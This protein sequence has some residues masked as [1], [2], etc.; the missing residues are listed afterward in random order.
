MFSDCASSHPVGGT[1][2]QDTEGVQ[3]AADGSQRPHPNPLQSQVACR[4]SG[5]AG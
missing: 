3:M 1:P 5:S 2:Y 4:M